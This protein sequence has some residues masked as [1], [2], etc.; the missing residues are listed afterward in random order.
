ME[1]LML[2]DILGEV[3]IEVT[4]LQNINIKDSSVQTTIFFVDLERLCKKKLVKLYLVKINDN[5]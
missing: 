1:E 4:K 3:L 2:L 5:L